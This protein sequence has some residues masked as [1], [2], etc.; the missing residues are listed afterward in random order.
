MTLKGGTIVHSQLLSALSRMDTL[1]VKMP[2]FLSKQ[3]HLVTDYRV[4]YNWNTHLYSNLLNQLEWFQ[5]NS[6]RPGA[7]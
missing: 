1:E 6:S 2:H 7:D 4:F 3:S 5:F